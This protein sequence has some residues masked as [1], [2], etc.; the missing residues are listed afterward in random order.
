MDQ[1]WAAIIAA[2]AAG[3]FGITGVFAGIVVGRRQTVDQAAVEHGQWLRDQRLQAYMNLFTTWDDV[4]AD[5]RSFQDRW[6]EEVESLQEIGYTV[7]PSAVAGQKT[8][9]AW[10]RLRPVIERVEL[11][12]PARIYDAH[13]DLLAAWR[14]MSDV[15]EEQAS[16]EPY[17]SLDE[18]F[19]R[20]SMRGAVAR[21][22]FH[23]AASDVLR[24]PPS[25]QGEP[26]L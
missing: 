11:L 8:N 16:Q 14:D 5:L 9:E 6:N 1:G 10:A 19:D 24:T 15:L 18:E 21:S 17:S 25:P 4:F 26:S 20:A 12:G 13:G 3:V 22:N 23:T 2:I 7:H